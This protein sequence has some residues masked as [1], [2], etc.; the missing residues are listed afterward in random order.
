MIILKNEKI[1]RL[2]N[3]NNYKLI[4]TFNKGILYSVSLLENKRNQNQFY[5]KNNEF[6][7]D[8]LFKEYFWEVQKTIGTKVSKYSKN[9]IVQIIPYNPARIYKKYLNHFKMKM[10]IN[11]Q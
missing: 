3:Q 1:Q 8:E 11:E 7:K 6:D 2:S 4:N 5:L 9:K 10:K